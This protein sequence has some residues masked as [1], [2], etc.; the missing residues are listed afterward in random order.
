MKKLLIVI[1][2]QNDFVDGS[3]GTEEAQ[4][5]VPAVVSKIDGFDGDIYVTYDTHCENYLETAE[6]KNLPIP[7]C[8]K[9]T[10]GWKLNLDVQTALDKKIYRAIE[11]NTFGSVDLPK[12]IAENYEVSNL[13]IELIGLCTDICVV[14]NALILKANFPETSIIVDACCCAGV[15]TETHKSALTTMK[16]CQIDIVGE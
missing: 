11:K 2:M 4:A 10:D 7:H 1:D 16:C 6:G 5:I 12:L 14:S 13:E 8:I 3:L 9:G 15:S